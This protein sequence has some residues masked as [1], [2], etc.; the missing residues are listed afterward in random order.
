MTTAVRDVIAPAAVMS[1][2]VAYA[3]RELEYW[4][5]VRAQMSR[6]KLPWG[7]ETAEVMATVAAHRAYWRPDEVRVLVLSE[8]HVMTREAELTAAVPLEVFGHPGAP[9]RFVRLLYCLGYGERDLVQG[10]VHPNW[11]T[12]QFWKL[13]AAAVDPVIVPQVVERTQPELITRLT[14][15]LKVLETLQAR[16]VWLLDACPVALYAASQPK[17]RMALL[18]QAMEIA[19]AAYTREA[20]RAAAPKSVMIVG[21]MVF[22]GIGGRIRALLGPAVPVQWMYQPQAR[23]PVAEHVAGIAR[24][25]A[26]VQAAE[27]A[28]R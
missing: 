14:A 17:P 27:M 4:E 7:T 9:L 28:G 16:G 19:W 1:S 5:A 13:L 2:P 15:K 6:L 26:M 25:R 11:G 22:D 18:A 8:S 20:I 23:R 10:R 12:P 3:P 21:K 24:L